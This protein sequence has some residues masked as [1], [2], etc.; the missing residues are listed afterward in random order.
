MANGEAKT[1]AKT[2]TPPP[3]PKKRSGTAAGAL[4]FFSAGFLRGSLAWLARFFPGPR[5]SLGVERSHENA[6]EGFLSL[7]LSLYF[8]PSPIEA[9]LRVLTKVLMRVLTRMLTKVLMQMCTKRFGR[10]SR[11]LFSSF[12]FLRPNGVFRKQCCSEGGRHLQGQEAPN[13]HRPWSSIRRPCLESTAWNCL[14]PSDSSA[15][16]IWRVLNGVSAH[17]G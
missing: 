12:F 17:G 9:H 6:P 4:C 15:E 2:S 5:G 1:Q 7:S 16:Q 8:S 11:G 3:P 13:C 10:H 14:E